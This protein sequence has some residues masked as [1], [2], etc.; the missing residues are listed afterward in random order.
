MRV[1]QLID[2]LA[3][4]GAERMAVN[5]A[6]GLSEQISFSALVATRDE[7]ELKE[8][9]QE[10]VSYLFLGRKSTLDFNA[11]FRL[12]AF[13]KRNEITIVH[14]HGTSFFTAFLLKIVYPKVNIIWHEHYGAR[15]K[16]TLLEN[17][18]LFICTRFFNSILVVNLELEQWVRDTLRFKKVFFIP[19]FAVECDSAVKV[20]FL[21]GEAGK[22]IVCLA[23]LK[24]PK[25]HLAL[26]NAFHELQ[27]QQEGWSLH[28]VGKIYNDA[29][30]DA[31]KAYI[32]TN[33]LQ[34]CV[35]LLDVRSDVTAILSQATIGVL[36]STAEGF[37][38]S[39]LEYG[40]AKLAVV[41]TNVG[42]CSEIIQDGVTGLLFDPTIPLDLQHQLYNIIA[43]SN[44]N[45]TKIGLNLQ[46]V[47]QSHYSK[48]ALLRLLQAYYK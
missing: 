8:Q 47:V 10:V 28:F 6:N 22:R 39:L 48:E 31:I 9:L 12:K 1:L 11:I 16:E 26:V 19:N 13:V 40:L 7:G 33:L 35:F 21:Q 4:G 25:N 44:E 32:A 5:Y 17:W 36:A 18:I 20:T 27:L 46:K 38:V 30:S 34:D 24:N 15:V 29:Y 43:E 14:A 41:S 23:N 3:A 2:S 37:P 42:Y 45:R